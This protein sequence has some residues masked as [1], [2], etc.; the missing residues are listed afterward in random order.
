MSSLSFSN[1]LISMEF[2]TER[3]HAL[4][5]QFLFYLIWIEVSLAHN[6][7]NVHNLFFRLLKVMLEK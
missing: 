5:K 3:T 2:T 7:F 6:F 4:R 1:F